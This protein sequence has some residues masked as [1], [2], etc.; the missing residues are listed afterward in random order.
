MM[1]NMTGMELYA[2]LTR[3]APFDAASLRVQVRGLV[4]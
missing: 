3:L 2:E 1:P 4:G